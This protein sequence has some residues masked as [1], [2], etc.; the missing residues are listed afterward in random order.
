MR[1]VSCL[2]FSL[3]QMQIVRLRP[4]CH[5]IVTHTLKADAFRH[6]HKLPEGRPGR[7]T[8]SWA[9]AAPFR[10]VLSPPDHCEANAGGPR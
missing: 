4:K 1:A 10:R 3:F 7:Q 6:I 2:L 8:P 9:P 5:S